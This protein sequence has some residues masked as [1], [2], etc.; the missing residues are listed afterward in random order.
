MTR[1]NRIDIPINVKSKKAIKNLNNFAAKIKKIPKA[2]KQLEHQAKKTTQAMNMLTKA[3]SGVPIKGLT[4]NL[5]AMNTMWESS[6]MGVLGFNGSLLSV[7]FLGMQMKKTFDSALKSI[8]DGY[9]K[10]LPE[11]GAFNKLTTKLSANWEFFKFQLADALAKSPLFQKMIGFTIRLVK[12]FQNLSPPIKSMIGF[13]LIAGSIIG[14]LLFL[15]GV[16]GLGF[17][18]VADMVLSIN[19]GLVVLKANLVS[20]TWGSLLAYLPLLLVAAAL[21][22]I[23]GSIV[24]ATGKSE[25]MKT[26]WKDLTDSFSAFGDVILIII[27]T[28]LSPFGFKLDSIGVLFIWIAGITQFVISTFLQLG[29]GILWVANLALGA[30]GG[31]LA[32]ILSVMID[33]GQAAVEM[34]KAFDGGGADFSGF[35]ITTTAF[36]TATEKL[37]NMTVEF[38]KAAIEMEKNKISFDDINKSVAEFRANTNG[39]GDTTLTQTL[40]TTPA[41]GVTQ[42]TEIINVNIDGMSTIFGD[43]NVVKDFTN[44]MLDESGLTQYK[45]EFKTG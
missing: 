42:K 12:W 45:Q 40:Q 8:F 35:D 33:V 25:T 21:A 37:K 14:S 4:K 29:T 23:S 27:N 22:L 38:G 32:V 10:I 30:L 24:Y 39:I 15:I 9:K 6:K 18:G 1:N 7:M 36:D 26:K 2:F 31:A 43:T 13:L 3:T 20:F 17:A 16:M 44:K 11:G 41:T 5:G 28:I 19:K 34:W